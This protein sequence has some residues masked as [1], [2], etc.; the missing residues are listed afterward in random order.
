MIKDTYEIEMLRLAAR[1]TNVGMLSAVA[2]A[3]ET[4]IESSAAAEMAMRQAW[5]NEFPDY[6]VASFGGDEVGIVNALSCYATSGPRVALAANCP[7]NRRPQSGEV[8]LP[9][10]FATC[11]GYHAEN[12]RTVIIDILEPLYERAYDAML[13]ARKRAFATLRI[14]TTYGE[15]YE[16][17]VSAFKEA[18]FGDN[19]P[20]RVGHGI[21]LG[22]H[23]SPS[24]APRELAV[25]EPGMAITIEPGLRFPGWGSV[26]HSD[27]LILTGEGPEILTV[28]PS[29]GKLM[30]PSMQPVSR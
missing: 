27:T 1:L 15:V 28:E 26:R 5:Q 11:S 17:A 19:L 14:G 2:H 13:E 20:G 21:G 12:E 23:E 29:A 22:L 8:S 25:L 4:E 3:R 16:A 7:N 9:C 6:E 24:L 18:G 10:V 30:A